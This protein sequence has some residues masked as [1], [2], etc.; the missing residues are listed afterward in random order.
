MLF[1]IVIPIYNEERNI[2]PLVEAIV[3]YLGKEDYEVVFV[4]DGSSDSSVKAI[5]AMK[6]RFSFIKLVKFKRNYG[7]TPALD[8]GI[9]HAKGKY[10]IT[11]DG[12][13]QNSPED[14]PRMLRL[15]ENC[16]YD[17]ISGW[18][19][20]RRDSFSKR[21]TSIVAR[22]IRKLLTGEK[23][24]DLGCTLKLY[25]RSCFDNL[26]LYG[27]MHR[28]IPTLLRWEGYRI[29]EIKVRHYPRRYGKT[30]YSM[31]RVR[32]GFFDMLSA[33]LWHK[34]SIR[35]FHFFGILAILSLAI[36]ILIALYKVFV[37]LL[38]L[39]NPLN[40][41]P[42]LLAA[43][44]FIILGIQFFSLGFVSEIQTKHYFSNMKNKQYEVEK[45]Y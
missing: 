6:R 45:V 23:L 37:S 30:K 38:I 26:N 12:D 2:K 8:A 29:K 9:R 33:L 40:V 41:G 21:M 11:M 1:S 16:G 25:R 7:Q 43:V 13:L 15:A 10:V 35:P 28:F 4:D 31:N 44:L 18:R 17:V 24:H 42:L 20:N 27:E 22:N 32:K 19:Y 5:L 36:G 39:G 3:E 14:I 34:F